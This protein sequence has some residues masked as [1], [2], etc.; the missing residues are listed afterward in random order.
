[1]TSEIVR[2]QHYE[3]DTVFLSNVVAHE[4]FLAGQDYLR[5]D[6]EPCWRVGT[7]QPLPE[8]FEPV[9]ELEPGPFLA[10][11][12]VRGDGGSLVVDQLAWQG[13]AVR[14]TR[15]LT[16]DAASGLERSETVP[17]IAITWDWTP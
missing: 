10:Y 6:G 15:T 2:S 9:T 8:S 12:A 14:V 1:F 4:M 3:S 11:G 16:F 17:G 7:D 13:N 5:R